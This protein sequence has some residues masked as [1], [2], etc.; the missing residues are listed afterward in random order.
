MSLCRDS[1]LRK[2]D[3]LAYAALLAVGKARLGAGCI[4]ACES[5]LAMSLCRNNA[6][7]N[8][9]FTT[10]VTYLALGKTCLGTCSRLVVQDSNASVRTLGV[11]DKATVVAAFIIFIIVRMIFLGSSDLGN[12]YGTANAALNALGKTGGGTAGLL[13]RNNLF[14][15]SVRIYNALRNCNLTA[16]IAFLTFGKT[17]LGTGC[18]LALKSDLVMAGSL[19]L[20]L[21]NRSFTT[22]KTL[23][24]IGKTGLGACSRLALKSDLCVSVRRD[25]LRLYQDTLTNDTENTACKTGLGTGRRSSF[26]LM[27]G[28]VS[29]AGVSLLCRIAVNTLSRFLALG[30]AGRL[31]GLI[32]DAKVMLDLGNILALKIAASTFTLHYAAFIAIGSLDNLPF[33]EG[34]CVILRIVSAG[35]Q[36]HQG[37]NEN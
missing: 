13:G 20:G 17:C 30:L 32:P 5:D 23:L 22:S 31:V 25:N 9:G 26:Y 4:L 2:S 7:C 35:Y 10:L 11:T 27:Q 12:D 28:V 18:I 21:C 19:D 8:E 29:K 34:M 16:S 37:K 1:S 36:R 15:M 24:T 3:Y 33:T 14:G 6:L